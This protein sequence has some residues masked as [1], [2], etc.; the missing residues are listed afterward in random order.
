MNSPPVIPVETDEEVVDGC[1]ARVIINV[2]E[3][4]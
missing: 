1:L 2:S 4:A 3:I